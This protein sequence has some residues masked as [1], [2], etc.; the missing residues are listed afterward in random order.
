MELRDICYRKSRLRRQ[1]GGS[2]AEY[3]MAIGVGGVVTGL[4]VAL[5][6]HS[7]RT[8]ASLANYAE[9]NAG[10]IN[11]MDRLTREIRNSANIISFESH[12]IVLDVGSNQPPVT[13]NYSDLT[14]TLSRQQGTDPA[15]T[16]LSGCDSLSFRVYDPTVQSNSL[17]LTLSTTTN[18]AKAVRVEWVSS[19]SILGQDVNSANPRTATIV[20]RK[21]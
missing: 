4:A 5:V 3:L 17:A 1:H 16:I 18:D 14:K 12:R 11:T 7:G 20:L 15:T 21:P 8:F 2:L 9:L 6:L 19:R 13:Y 10:S